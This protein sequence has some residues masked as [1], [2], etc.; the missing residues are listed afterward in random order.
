MSSSRNST[1]STENPSEAYQ[2]ASGDWESSTMSRPAHSSIAARITTSASPWPRPARAITTRPI[3]QLVAVVEDARVA[4]QP[5]VVLEEQHVAGAGLA[6]AAVEVGVGALLLD[7]EDVL[8]QPPD[9]VRRGGVEVGEGHGAGGRHRRN[10]RVV[11]QARRASGING[12]SGKTW[13]RSGS[14]T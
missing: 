8:S 2:P 6:V 1:P 5:A 3:R 4:D 11:C 13:S 7:D 12:S 9:V 14:S 10:S